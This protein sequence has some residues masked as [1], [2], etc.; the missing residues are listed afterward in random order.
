MV[1]GLKTK[2]IQGPRLTTVLAPRLGRYFDML[3]L[4]A[5]QLVSAVESAVEEN[6][7]LMPDERWLAERRQALQL[8]RAKP[9]V[10]YEGEGDYQDRDSWLA[11]RPKS[12]QAHLLSE[13]HLHAENERDFNLGLAIIG[14][15]NE[16]GFLEKPLE[17][18]AP[19]IE[20]TPAELEEV[21]ERVV[22]KFEPPGIGA[23]SLQEALILQIKAQ[24]PKDYRLM[25]N[26]VECYLDDISKGDGKALARKMKIEQKRA[27]K[28]VKYIG[29]LEPVPARSFRQG[30]NP[31]ISV[32]LLAKMEND[33]IKVEYLQGT[34][35]RV[36][37]NDAYVKLLAGNSA[38][39][40][41]E[42]K[43]LHEKLALARDFIW[44]LERRQE[45]V[46]AVARA[47]LMSQRG[48]FR[49]GEKAMRPLKLSDIAGQ[50]G[51]SVSTVSR[52]VAGKKIETPL[53]IFPLKYFFN[54][55]VAGHSRHTILETIAHLVEKEPKA[56][57]LVD[58]DIVKAL[59]ERGIR[60]ARRTVAKYR[61]IL[62]IPTA[63]R[64]KKNEG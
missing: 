37:L 24:Q 33:D 52:A 18:I 51:Y 47:V 14:E 49:R 12:L 44:A 48:F 10:G 31:P 17:D 58:D 38:V 32:D 11:E 1:E 57:P 15:I 7:F 54:P 40:P 23:R 26:A 30:Y 43:F 25:L 3:P 22:F 5:D 62:G 61:K 2:I 6:P 50:V 8:R 53:G 4:P 27:E 16:D 63:G 42:K 60:I 9:L 13:L 35:P 46:L 29:S 28:I 55:Q 21:L 41:E 39:T 56:R 19:W 36:Y 45:T 20:A 64:R 34:V 59:S